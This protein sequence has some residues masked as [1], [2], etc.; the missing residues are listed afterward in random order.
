MIGINNCGQSCFIEL[1]ET[2]FSWNSRDDILVSG[3]SIHDSNQTISIK[4]N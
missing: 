1:F 3:I 4:L 2:T